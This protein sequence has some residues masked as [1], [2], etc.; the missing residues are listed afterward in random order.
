MFLLWGMWSHCAVGAGEGDEL[1]AIL[2]T[3]EQVRS[4]PDS[5]AAKGCPV[6]LRG[7]VTYNSRGYFLLFLQDR[8]GTIYIEPG[9]LPDEL[10]NCMAGMEI[11][12]EGRTTPRGFAPYVRGTGGRIVGTGPM[13]EPRWL[14]ADQAADPR[15]DCSYVEMEGVVRT[16]EFHPGRNADLQQTKLRIGA[17]AGRFPA[18]ING[19]EARNP[20]LTN[21]VGSLV[22]IRGVYGSLY[23]EN[24]Q[25][26]GF[27]ILL[28]SD[29]NI[30]VKTPAGPDPFL[31][32]PR[33]IRTLMQFDTGSN[34]SLRSLVSGRVTLVRRDHFYLEDETGGVEVRPAHD[35]M[36]KEGDWIR[37]AGFPA[38]AGWCLTLDDAEF[39]NNEPRPAVPPPLISVEQALSGDFAGC[40]VWMDGVLLQC[41]AQPG[42]AGP[43]L[44]LQDGEQVFQVEAAA[45]GVARHLKEGSWIH[46]SGICLNQSGAQDGMSPGRST[47]DKPSSF[48]LVQGAADEVRIIRA[49]TWWTGP[50]LVAIC[51]G[52]CGLVFVVGLWGL[53]LKRQVAAK[54][55]IISEQLNRQAVLEE[56]ERIARELHDTLEQEMTGVAMQLDA[57]GALLGSGDT[58]ARDAIETA[59][60]LLDR[61]RAGARDSIWEL[62]HHSAQSSPTLAE[63][64]CNLIQSFQI[65]GA[66]PIKLIRR[67]PDLRAPRAAQIHLIRIVREAVTNAIKHSGAL[68]IE[69]GLE[70]EPGRVLL[71]VRDNGCGFDTNANPAWATRHFGIL[72]MRE[73]AAKIR[74][75][76][77]IQVTPGGGTT[78]T[79]TLNLDE[80]HLS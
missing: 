10:R 48:R 72:G 67:G 19:L 44:L 45:P 32:A 55:R 40:R 20:S 64:I 54:T 76:L 27:Q 56:R 16:V 69:V 17:G 78:V 23:N 35:S 1:P 74:A 41:V 47:R 50:R 6:R 34:A 38:W 25:L 68:A 13:P 31:S 12:L 2:N 5:E 11:E 65:P 26:T 52:L 77:Q 37:V 73:R 30:V 49:P 75:A 21:L 66:P 53:L 42:T 9:S 4:L 43:M 51:G 63:E 8:T 71:R 46:I 39:V 24:L 57:A 14:P 7:V 61:S 22:R 59:R 3:V 58:R 70:S 28:S 80:R 62:R 33:S 15:N 18:V 29:T 36:P 79:V 60:L